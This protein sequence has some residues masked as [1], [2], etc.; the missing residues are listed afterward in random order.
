MMTYTTTTTHLLGNLQASTRQPFLILPLKSILQLIEISRQ[1]QLLLRFLVCGYTT[2]KI[3]NETLL[4]NRL[5]YRMRSED[6]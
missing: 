2:T 4:I 5:G 3:L 1:F 6:L